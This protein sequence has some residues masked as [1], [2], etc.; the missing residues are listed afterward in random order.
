MPQDSVLGDHFSSHFGEGPLADGQTG[1]VFDRDSG[2]THWVAL[3]IWSNESGTHIER[4]ELKLR[5]ISGT[6]SS[7][8][9]WEGRAS[10]DAGILSSVISFYSTAIESVENWRDSGNHEMMG[11]VLYRLLIKSDQLSRHMHISA[12]SAEMDDRKRK[13]VDVTNALLDAPQA[14]FAD[15]AFQRS[16]A[17]LIHD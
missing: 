5:R 14:S 12:C 4:K 6:V 16:L 13:F 3:R 2:A 17:R 9:L 11:G 1:L 8:P 15:P 7:Y 10:I